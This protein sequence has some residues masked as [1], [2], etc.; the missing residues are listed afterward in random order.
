MGRILDVHLLQ[1][2]E[3]VL[4]QQGDNLV[5]LLPDGLREDDVRAALAKIGLEPSREIVLWWGR[6]DGWRDESSFEVLPG[7]QSLSLYDAV[8]AYRVLRGNAVRTAQ[9]AQAP[10]LLRDPD[11]IFH[12]AWLPIFTTGGMP[13]IVIDGHSALRQVDPS[14]VGQS[15]HAEVFAASLGEFIESAVGVLERGTYRYDRRLLTW[16]PMT[17]TD[18]WVGMRFGDGGDP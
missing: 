6:H 16:T 15:D 18:H 14:E 9:D 10:E 8:E 12:R 11:A 13:T 7:L 4:A 2:L 3:Q 1:R 17:W 5:R